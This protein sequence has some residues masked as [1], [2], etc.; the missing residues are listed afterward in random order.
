MGHQCN[1][2][3]ESF[4]TLSRLRL[5]EQ[6]DCP[7]RTTYDS[8]DPDD[9]ETGERAATG[10][11][12]CRRCDHENTETLFNESTSFANGELHL[13]VEFTCQQCGFE[14]E[15][16]IVMEGVSRD[17]LDRLPPHLKPSSDQIDP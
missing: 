6:D 5:H 16:R 7:A 13:I 2:C 12:T 9:P 4:S 3:G 8:F 11:L 17:D 1:A 10:L 14:N 15:N